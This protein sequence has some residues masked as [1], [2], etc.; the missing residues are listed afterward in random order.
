MHSNPGGVGQKAILPAKTNGGP[1][2]PPLDNHYNNMTVKILY[3]RIKYFGPTE[4]TKSQ[5]MSKCAAVRA[6]V[7]SSRD[8]GQFS[9]SDL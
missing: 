9:Q 6:R 4:R 8:L 3:G 5:V 2:D 7:P 1:G